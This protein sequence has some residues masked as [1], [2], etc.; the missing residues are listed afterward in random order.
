MNISDKFIDFIIF[1]TT[2]TYWNTVNE[3]SYTDI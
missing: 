1:M 3:H 2:L